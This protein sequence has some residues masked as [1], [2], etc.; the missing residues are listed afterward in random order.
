MGIGG[1]LRERFGDRPVIEKVRENLARP[2]PRFVN[3]WY[4]LGTA[5]LAFLGIQFLTGILLAL[6][7]VPT[8]SGAPESIRVITGQVPLGWL[9]RSLH[10]WGASALVILVTLHMLK[11][12]WTAAYRPP[13][14]LT[15]VAGVLLLGIVMAFGLTGYLLPWD[16]LAYWG[17]TVVTDSFGAVPLVGPLL[18]EVMRGGSTV[19]EATLQRFYIAHILLLPGALVLVVS[20]HLVLVRWFGTSPDGDCGETP[21]GRVPEADLDPER[22]FWPMQVLRE[23]PLVYLVLGI[24][25]TLAVLFAPGAGPTADPFSTPQG[26]KPEWYFLPNYQLFKYMPT[27]L[28]L[29]L[30]T[31]GGL[32]V[33]ALPWWDRS[34]IRRLPR[35]PLAR[36]VVLGTAVGLVGLGSLGALSETSFQVA[37]SRV[38]FDIQG[39]PRIAPLSGSERAFEELASLPADTLTARTGALL[40]TEC[41][42]CHG[43]SSPVMGLSLEEDTFIARTVG[44][45][46]RQVDLPL[47]APGDPGGSYLYL[48]VTG[49]EGIQG[50]RM[51]LTGSELSGEQLALIRAWIEEGAEAAAPEGTITADSEGTGQPRLGALLVIWAVLGFGMYAAWMKRRQLEEEP[52]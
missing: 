8:S 39:V 41:T 21:D 36:W 44:E 17:T 25:A 28:G 16:Q 30:T 14:E 1:W 12:L 27:W 45:S 46:A 52:A 34:P 29:L 22:P 51:P 33:I 11:A 5:M 32:V 10:H 19:G 48:K 42:M 43:G 15:W 4:A 7:Y 35:R 24:G 38:S 49:A 47:V 26:I 31:L 9:V 13:R 18:L 37:G 23:L 6:Y 40:G 20:A 50:S 2:V 3:G